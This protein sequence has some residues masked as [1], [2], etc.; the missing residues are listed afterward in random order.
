MTD[1]SID[2]N[3][4]SAHTG[5]AWFEQCAHQPMPPEV[6]ARGIISAGLW[7]EATPRA[8]AGV[9]FPDDRGYR[10][11]GYCGSIHPED[12]L[13]YIEREEVG[14]AEMADRKY[15]YPH[16][17]YV[18]VR[19][20]L[21][22][23]LVSRS[24]SSEP[25]GKGGYIQAYGEPRPDGPYTHAKFYTR[26]LLGLDDE[27]FG[28]LTAWLERATGWRFERRDDGMYWQRV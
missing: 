4:L 16:K 18:D 26:H 7:Q 15:G 22:G 12:L 9:D 14:R 2:P 5:D 3:I 24:M 20:P 13:G 1:Y 23:Q 25:D 8:N 27:Q 10:A 28:A 11:C 6:Q 19:N 21:A 17:V